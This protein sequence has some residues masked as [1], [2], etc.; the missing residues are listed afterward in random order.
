MSYFDIFGDAAQVRD[1][2][3]E[4]CLDFLMQEL[5]MGMTFCRIVKSDY[6]ELLSRQHRADADK[7]HRTALRFTGTL[8]LNKEERAAFDKKRTHT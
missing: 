6:S 8:E 5:E 3:H 2:A 1:R 4:V 7:A